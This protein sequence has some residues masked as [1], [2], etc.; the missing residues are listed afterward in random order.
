MSHGMTVLGVAELSPHAARVHAMKNCLMT[1]LATSRLAERKAG[2]INPKL[3]THLQSAA[4]RLRDLLAQDLATE[5]AAA[6]P[7]HD[8]EGCSVL[9]AVRQPPE[10]R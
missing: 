5:Q 8:G 9:S 4:H 10:A 1:V 2:N 7:I 6:F 3:W